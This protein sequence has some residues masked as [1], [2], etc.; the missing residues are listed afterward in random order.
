MDVFE[1]LERLVNV[2]GPSGREQAIAATITELW[3]PYV[4][5]ITV[6][7]IGNLVALKKGEG[8]SPRPGLLIAAHMDE[9]ALIVTQLDSHPNPDGAGFLRVT[10]VGGVD[11]RQLYGQLVLIHGKEDLPGI[12]GALPASMLPAPRRTKPY[13]Y[14]EIVVDPGL[15][16]HELKTRVSVGDFISFQQPLHRTQNGTATG[17]SLDNRASVAA[18]TVAL[19]Y[20]KHRTHTWDIYAVATAQEETGLL[21]AATSAHHLKPDLAIALDVTFGKSPGAKDNGLTFA[22]GSGP[23]LGIG[24]NL[25]PGVMQALHDTATALEM[26][27]TVEPLPRSSGTDAITLQIARAGIPTGLIGLPLRYMHTMVEMIS[28]K[29]IERSGRLLG[30]LI[31]RLDNTFLDTLAAEMMD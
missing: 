8:K 25:H 23:V 1:T 6:D 30:E 20:L 26:K 29:D 27:T 14:Q 31:T 21:G 28:L 5:E 22:L 18:V 13:N 3:Q 9:I 16:Y 12:I 4:D 24:P 2:P 10:Q 15:P 17:K 19:D 11:R 7:R